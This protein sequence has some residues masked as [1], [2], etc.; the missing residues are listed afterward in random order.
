MTE[1]M[2]RMIRSE[3][4]GVVSRRSLFCG[5]LTFGVLGLGGAGLLAPFAGAIGP[6]RK[7]VSGEDAVVAFHADRLYLDRS[8]KAEPYRAP[9]GLRSLEGLAEDDLRRLVYHP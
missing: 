6:V 3:P 4:M 8:G 2:G 9:A 7:A 5:A 1:Q